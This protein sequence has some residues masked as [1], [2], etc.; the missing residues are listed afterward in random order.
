MPD[1]LGSSHF[2]IAPG[3]V[4]AVEAA[5][6]LRVGSFVYDNDFR[7]P[8]LLAQEIATIDRLTDGRFEFGIG[9]GWQLRDYEQTG[10][11]FDAGA[12]RVARMEE[13][14]QLILRLLQETTVTFLGTHYQVN[15]AEGYRCVQQPHPPVLIGGGGPRLL[16]FAA[17]HADIISVLPR[18]RADGQG[19]DVQDAGATSFDQKISW[20]R[21]AAPSRFAQLEINVLIQA[22]VLTNDRTGVAEMLATQFHAPV[23]E[24]LQSPLI[25]VGTADQIVDDLEARRERF[26]IT[27]ITVFDRDMEAM[28]P[29]IER[30]KGR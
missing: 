8:V 27:Y 1:H 25:L 9:A 29:V 13:S 4:M 23:A 3:L 6:A 11:A 7:N 10:L 17:G 19:F 5:P 26:G 12:V 18:A 15:D 14:L 30:L 21:A 2:A 24:L 16:S 20:I 28:A 22:V